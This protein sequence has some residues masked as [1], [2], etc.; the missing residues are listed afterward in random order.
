LIRK[1]Y[2]GLIVV[3][4]QIIGFLLGFQICLELPPDWLLFETKIPVRIIIPVF[5]MFIGIAVGGVIINLLGVELT[6]QEREKARE[7]RETG[8]Q[9][10]GLG[11]ILIGTLAL[12]ASSGASVY[13]KT[14]MQVVGILMLIV[15][16]L[17]AVNIIY[18]LFS[19]VSIVL[20]YAGYPQIPAI[21]IVIPFLLVGLLGAGL[22][23]GGREAKSAVEQKH[24]DEYGRYKGYSRQHGDIIEHYD[25]YDRY[26]GYSQRHGNT[27]RRYDECG[28]FIGETEERGMR[29]ENKPPGRE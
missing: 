1:G 25:E 2:A 4:C 14:E 13:E 27:I 5:S 22:K 19:V 9:A 20:V 28:R 17:I 15:G 23:K 6:E 29:R 10:A 21:I 3:V 12:L 8:L 11:F 24:Y 7:Q 16:S 26:R 18:L